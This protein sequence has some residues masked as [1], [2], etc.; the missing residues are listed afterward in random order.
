MGGKGTEGFLTADGKFICVEQVTEEF[1]SRGNFIDFQ[2][3]FLCDQVQGTT[4]WHTP[5]QSQD[6]GFLEIGNCLCVMG[7]DGNGIRRTYEGIISVNH[8]PITITVGSSAKGDFLSIDT[9][10]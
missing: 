8:I 2:F 4:G 7:D 6:S 10:N 1:P 9:F 5:C 3:E